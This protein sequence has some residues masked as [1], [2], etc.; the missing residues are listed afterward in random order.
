MIPIK[1]R[2]VCRC[3][4]CHHT[5]SA[6]GEGTQTHRPTEDSEAHNDLS[7]S[8]FQFKE[9]YT[10]PGRETHLW[11]NHG[12]SIQSRCMDSAWPRFGTHLH[13]PCFAY[14]QAL[15]K[16]QKANGGN[17]HKN[18]DCLRSV[19]CS[20]QQVPERRAERGSS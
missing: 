8:N 2:R 1:W 19:C 11:K 3:T 20:E 12:S 10:R 6:E 15:G 7:K 9:Y 5:S 18:R 17:F 16:E 4:P 14:L 13:V